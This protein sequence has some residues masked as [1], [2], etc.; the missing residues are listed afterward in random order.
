MQV[1]NIARLARI[2]LS[3]QEKEELSK[4]LEML[5]QRFASIQV[6]AQYSD[7]N[8][9]A[10]VVNSSKNEVRADILKPSMTHEEIAQN[11]PNFQ[12]SFFIVPQI[13]AQ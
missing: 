13:L 6:D 8:M 10:G 9:D 4:D 12:N 7:S 2:K 11:A 3:T 5:L 1:E